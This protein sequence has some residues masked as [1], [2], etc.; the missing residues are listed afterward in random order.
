M[1]LRV[2]LLAPDGR[3]DPNVTRGL[4]ANEAN[5]H[6]QNANASNTPTGVAQFND[7]P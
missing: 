4:T 5:G 1:V 6:R 7:L 3:E 2:R